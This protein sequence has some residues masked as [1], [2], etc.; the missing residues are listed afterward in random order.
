M[1]MTQD[2]KTTQNKLS[3][4]RWS[5]RWTAIFSIDEFV[6]DHILKMGREW[7][8]CL[9]KEFLLVPKNAHSRWVLQSPCLR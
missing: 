1:C 4:N 7:T 3:S 9:M 8:L 6:A 5:D 2:N